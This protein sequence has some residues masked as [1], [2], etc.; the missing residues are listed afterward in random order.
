[1]GDRANVLVFADK[2]STG[3]YLYTH[4]TGTELP[5]DV[6]DAL[7]R[8]QRWDDPAYLTRI[9]FCTMARNSFDM[10]TRY[11]ISTFPTD[12]MNRVLIVHV[13]SQEVQRNKKTWSFAEFAALTDEECNAV[14]GNE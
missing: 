4:W 3:I 13:H 11:G 6:R 5:L 10:E 9:I 1:M 14:W 12:G 7:A 8:H 2:D